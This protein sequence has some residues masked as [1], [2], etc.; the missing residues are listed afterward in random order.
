MDA[1][2]FVKGAT[3][4][5]HDRAND[6]VGDNRA[7]FTTPLVGEWDGLT[8]L[9][10][11]NLA[12]VYQTIAM[13]NSPPSDSVDAADRPMAS[14]TATSIKFGTNRIRRSEHEKYEAYALIRTT[15]PHDESLLNELNS[16]PGY[17]GSALVEGKFDI[18]LLLG[19]ATED[20]LF[21]RIATTRSRINTRGR[22]I[23]CY[24]PPLPDGYDS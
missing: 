24:Q 6:L 14:S 10:D 2:H 3:P 5:F 7:R 16:V 12:D 1:Y 17:T 4:T 15:R 8:I 18:L 21:A 20:E 23:V 9:Y 22:A 19:G 13:L 11:I